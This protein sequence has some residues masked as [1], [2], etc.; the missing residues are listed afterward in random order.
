MIEV[1]YLKIEFLPVFLPVSRERRL[2]ETG[3]FVLH[4]LDIDAFGDTGRAHALNEAFALDVTMPLSKLRDG[5]GP[6]L[7]CL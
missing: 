5:T 2:P 7:R 4:L 1:S 3:Q 6:P